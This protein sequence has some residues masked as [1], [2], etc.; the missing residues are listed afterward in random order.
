MADGLADPF[1]PVD[2]GPFAGDEGGTGFGTFAGGVLCELSAGLRKSVGRS[3]NS[4]AVALGHPI[5]PVGDG[6]GG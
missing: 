1:P 2:V 6:L 5:M 3:G 4:E